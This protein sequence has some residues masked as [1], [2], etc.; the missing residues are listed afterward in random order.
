MNTTDRRA[1][2]PAVAARPGMFGQMAATLASTR[3]RRAPAVQRRTELGLVLLAALVTVAAYTLTW[4][5]LK[6]RLSSTLDI[7][8]AVVVG[9][10][11][12]AHL[13]TRWLAPRAD[14]VL[15]PTVV[16]LNGLGW[17]MI[18][19]LDVHEALMQAVWSTV[20]VG[21]YVVTLALVRRS[22]DLERYRYLMAL[23][24]VVLLLLPLVPH[25]GLNINGARLWI[26]LGPLTFQPVQVAQIALVVFFAS[27]FGEK[28]ELLSNPTMRI[29]N[30]LLP[31]PRIA[32]PIVAAWALSMLVMTAERNVGFALLIFVLFLAMLWVATGRIAFLAVGMVLFGVGAWVGSLLFSQVNERITVWLNPW[33]YANGIGYQLVQA[34]YALGTGGVTGTGLGLGHPY[35][36]PVV[37]SDFIFAAFGEE[38]GL[39]GTSALLVAFLVLVAVGFRTALRARA[40]FSKL[41]AAGLTAVLGFQSFFI[42]AGIAR[43]L[44][45]TGVTLPFVAYGGSSLVSSYLLVALLVRVS[46]E[47]ASA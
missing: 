39:L 20:G 44:P 37:T 18:A 21:V 15:V 16:L 27:S 23:A 34:Q 19:R 41:M 35:Y 26:K 40:D 38:L 25:L 7:W 6:G 3:P 22:R 42:M 9:L 11:L 43:L 28:R 45:L 14:P 10:G 46:H 2:D 5:G 36:I 32:G 29:G 30:H 13:F 47:S 24:G 4:F 1:A 33:A 8:L 31:D 12:V 17:V